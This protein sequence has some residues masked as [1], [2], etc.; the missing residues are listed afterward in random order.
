MSGGKPWALLWPVRVRRDPPGVGRGG[1]PLAH[2]SVAQLGKRYGARWLFRGVEFSLGDGDRL[3][4]TGPNGSGKSTLLRIAAGL[5]TPTSGKVERCDRFGYAALD[6][7]L[8]GSLS[9]RDHLEWA[10]S[11]RGISPETERWSEATG[12][13]LELPVSAYSTGMRGRLKLALAFQGQPSLVFL[14]EPSAALDTAGVH[15]L[16]RLLAEHTGAAVIATNSLEDKK[17][18]TSELKLD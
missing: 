15:L 8:Y 11:Q 7:S 4:L 5:I 10:A 13:D 1:A 3:L 12:L 6:Q 9:A 2:L 14:D 18:G 16:D 17:Y